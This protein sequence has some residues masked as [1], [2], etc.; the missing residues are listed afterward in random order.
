MG[1]EE[2]SVQVMGKND[3]TSLERIERAQIDSLV[4]TAKAYPRDPVACRD[5]AIAIATMDQE[6]AQECF[7]V[8]RRGGNDIEGPS[9]RCAE[10]VASTWQNIRAGSRVLEADATTVSA[11]AFC[12]D[13]ENNVFIVKETKRR[14]TNKDG[15]RYNDDMIVMTGNAAA[16]VALRNAVFG[17]V[18][19]AVVRSVYLE[20]KKVAVGTAKTLAQRLQR[21]VK[22]FAS[23][24]VSEEQLLVFLAR[25]NTE[26]ITPDDLGKL[27]GVFNAL[28]EG[29]QVVDEVFPPIVEKKPDVTAGEPVK[30]PDEEK[31]AKAAAAKAKK[32]EKAAK[33]AEAEAVKTPAPP[34]DPDEGGDA[35]EPE[36]PVEEEQEGGPFAA[37]KTG[38][39]ENQSGLESPE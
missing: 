19:K 9:I 15:K 32:E 6:T 14:I 8:L 35:Q 33:K 36:E 2:T 37:K 1:N 16:A 31:A 23:I 7:Y 22:L 30:K 29:E 11:Q 21:V 34:P 39:T 20:A 4:S 18:P 27:Q 3:I 5:K 26:E 10:I 17:T 28:K 24:P 38:D 13:T 25:R 12:H